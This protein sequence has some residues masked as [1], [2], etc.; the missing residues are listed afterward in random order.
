MPGPVL[1]LPA[2]CRSGHRALS[3]V[4]LQH[5]VSL[6]ATMLSA[7]HR[8]DN[9]YIPEPVSQPQLNAFLYKRCCGYSVS[10][11]KQNTDKTAGFPL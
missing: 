6:H 3:Q 10:S 11:Q 7:L 4:L 1:L 5:H 8:D 2:A 9:Q